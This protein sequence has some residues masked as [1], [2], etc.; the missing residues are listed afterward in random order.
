MN[1]PEEGLAEF[2][3]FIPLSF[4]FRIQSI[5]HIYLLVVSMFSLLSFYPW[6]GGR[7]E[8]FLHRNLPIDTYS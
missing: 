7:T 6:G 2:N 1:S 5:C 8:V 3:F 4:I